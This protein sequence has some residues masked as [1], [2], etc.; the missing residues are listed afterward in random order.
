[1]L[2]TV[3]LRLQESNTKIWSEPLYGRSWDYDYLII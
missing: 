2:V 3:H 1:M